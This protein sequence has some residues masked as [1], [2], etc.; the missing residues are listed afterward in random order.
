[1]Q[2]RYWQCIEIREKQR[3][4]L[5]VKTIVRARLILPRRGRT[6]VKLQQEWKA[7]LL[8][9]FDHQVHW[10]QN[11]GYRVRWDTDYVLKK[12][13]KLGPAEEDPLI[14]KPAY[15]ELL[16]YAIIIEGF[17]D[18][19][20]FT[21]GRLPEWGSPESQMPVVVASY[22]AYIANWK[23]LSWPDIADEVRNSWRLSNP[24]ESASEDP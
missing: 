18:K 22:T 12:I 1:M 4:P 7:I 2:D 9:A 8:D 13:A 21:L 11:D 24:C 23:E 19:A 3:T 16:G 14:D 10:P 5:A 15:T 6:T 20:V 17:T